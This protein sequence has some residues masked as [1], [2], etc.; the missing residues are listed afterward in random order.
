LFTHDS[1][2][3]ETLFFVKIEKGKD[4]VRNWK[5][6][7][8]MATCLCAM[9]VA[10][11]QAACWTDTAIAAARVRS[12]DTMLMVAA[13]RCRGS[14]VDVMAS[15]N[16]FVRTNRATLSGVNDTLRGHFATDGGITAYDRY[17]T[18][19]ANRYGGGVDGMSCRDMNSIVTEATDA[20]GSFAMLSELAVGTNIVP[21]LPGGRCVITARR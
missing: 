11:A 3:H 14:G 8:V 19:I 12:M 4:A 5:R 9:P 21:E 2:L 13:L 18:S 6:S 17:V 10:E 20:R 7:M 16:G 15:Y 1:H